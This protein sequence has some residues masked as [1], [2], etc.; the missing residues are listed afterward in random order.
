MSDAE[1]MTILVLFH[2]SGCRALKAF[3]LGWVFTR[4][5]AQGRCTGVSIVD[6]TPLAAFHPKRTRQL[7]T[8]QGLAA[9]SQGAMGWVYGF[10]LHLPVN[11]TGKIIQAM[12]TPANTN[13]RASLAHE[14][15]TRNLFGR[16]VGEKR[17][18]LRI[19]SEREFGL[20]QN[21]IHVKKTSVAH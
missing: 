1:V 20:K 15:I 4:G 9:H 18:I 21:G 14:A 13:D 10:K 3:H 8:M 12:L 19:F 7:R 11:A 2:T 5:R 17:Y 6:S 16:L